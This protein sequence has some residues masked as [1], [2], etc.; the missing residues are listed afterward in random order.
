MY[1]LSSNPI[2][3]VLIFFFEFFCIIADT[4][5]ESIPPER[6]EPTGTSAIITTLTG[7]ATATATVTRSRPA[8][9]SISA[10]ATVNSI[11]VTR[12]R[13][14]SASIAGD[15]TA[16]ATV[17]KIFFFDPALFS[18]NRVAKVPFEET[19]IARVEFQI[20]RQASVPQDEFRNVKV[21]A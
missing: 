16:T 13:P 10:D 9:A 21:A 5:V 20:L 14:A 8:S 17:A 3:K 11:T 18:K 12:N 4:V 6:K 7:D 2:E 1:P 19:R 15:A